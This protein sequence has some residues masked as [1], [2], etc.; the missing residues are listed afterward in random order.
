MPMQQGVRLDDEQGLL[1]E[2]SAASQEDQS[3]TIAIGELGSFHLALEH[4][5]LLSQHQILGDQIS[6]AAAYV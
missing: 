6:A 5:E 4:D 2:L 1:P 3:E